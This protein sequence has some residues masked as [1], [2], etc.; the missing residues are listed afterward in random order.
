[1]L[2][3][4]NIPKNSKYLLI[5]MF[6][7]LGKDYIKSNHYQFYNDNHSFLN[8]LSFLFLF[9]FY[10]WEKNL[11]KKDNKKEKSTINNNY[12]IK[13]IILIISYLMFY[14]IYNYI[15]KFT[16]DEF[17]LIERFN[18]KFFLFVLI[19]LIFF[20]K[21]IY[22]HHIISIIIPFIILIYYRWMKDFKSTYFFILQYYCLDY[23][24][25][26]LNLCLEDL[27]SFWDLIF[28]SYCY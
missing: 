25:Y 6:S 12:L 17:S 24:Y 27:Y 28:H 26:L 8:S 5:L 21:Y 3:S 9:F 2:I 15:F 10:L 18:M 4:I 13:R 1:M 23:S 20:K 14:V 22:S 19:E 7:Q 11:S 16:I